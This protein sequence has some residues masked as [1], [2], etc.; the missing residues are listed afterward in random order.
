MLDC[1]VSKSCPAHPLVQEVLFLGDGKGPKEI[2]WVVSRG[3]C[4]WRGRFLAYRGMT[5]SE[6]PVSKSTLESCAGVPTFIKEIAMS[7]FRVFRGKSDNHKN[8]H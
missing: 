3:V 6:D 1:D 8:T 4:K 2:G 7:F 5:R